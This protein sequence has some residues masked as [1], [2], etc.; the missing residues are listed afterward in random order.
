[1]TTSIFVHGKTW[2]DKANGNSYFSAKIYVDGEQVAF[3][4]FQYGY[5]D[6][7]E[8]EASQV[9]RGL[10]LL[11]EGFPADNG[12]SSAPLWRLRDFGVHYYHSISDAK[13]RDVVRWGK[14]W[15]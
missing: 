14:S 11:P 8:Y 3:L 13:K 12:G 6:Q 7:Y 1:M 5:G 15:E 10:G 9:L 2:F 4:P